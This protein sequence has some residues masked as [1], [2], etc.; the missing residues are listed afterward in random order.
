MTTCPHGE[1]CPAACL[2]CLDAEMIAGAQRRR[3]DAVD[4]VAKFLSMIADRPRVTEADAFAL[5]SDEGVRRKETLGEWLHLSA[6][7][8]ATLAAMIRAD[9]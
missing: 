3:L 2:T 1:P 7:R 8:L 6:S 9:V 4:D 5:I